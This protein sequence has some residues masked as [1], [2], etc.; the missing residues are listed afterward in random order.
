MA[1]RLRGDGRPEWSK[2]VVRDRAPRRSLKIERG[3]AD[4]CGRRRLDGLEGEH[5]HLGI[6][7]GGGIL[8]GDTDEDRAF[9]IHSVPEVSGAHGA[10]VAAG[11]HRHRLEDG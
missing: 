5:Q 2:P 1:Y 8:V 11:S 10:E 6:R 4:L 7:G 3:D 9:W